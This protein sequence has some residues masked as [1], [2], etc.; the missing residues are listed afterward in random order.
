MVVLSKPYYFGEVKMGKGR[1]CLDLPN[2]FMD[3]KLK[4][5]LCL[6]WRPKYEYPPNAGPVF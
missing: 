3:N 1:K 6:I 4:S 2:P 5:I